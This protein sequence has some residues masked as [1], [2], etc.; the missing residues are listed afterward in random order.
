LLNEHASTSTVNTSG[1]VGAD[2]VAQMRICRSARKA[3]HNDDVL[4]QKK[5]FDNGRNR[6]I[7]NTVYLTV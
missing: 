2:G 4:H 3:R 6:S 5:D 1:A 7:F